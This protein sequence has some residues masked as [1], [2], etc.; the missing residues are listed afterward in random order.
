MSQQYDIN[1]TLKAKINIVV[2]KCFLPNTGAENWTFAIKV[3]RLK[4][5]LTNLNI[6]LIPHQ[7]Q[8]IVGYCT[9]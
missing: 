3:N 7:S 1:S 5:Y 4:L 2:S 8:L 9:S 6:K